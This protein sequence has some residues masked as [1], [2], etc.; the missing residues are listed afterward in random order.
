MRNI[1]VSYVIDI[2]ENSVKD[3]TMPLFDLTEVKI[4]VP[5][6]QIS[7]EVHSNLV[8]E[9]IETLKDIFIENFYQDFVTNITQSVSKNF[10][11]RLNK[12]L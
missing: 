2:K 11:I 10:P 3:K 7:Y 9:L 4:N 12:A 8:Q 1:S 6:K 5:K